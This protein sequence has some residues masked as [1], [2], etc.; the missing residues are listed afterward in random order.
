V[1]S[2]ARSF[3][4]CSTRS[5]FGGKYYRVRPLSTPLCVLS[6]CV[7]RRCSLLTDPPCC[8]HIELGDCVAFMPF[9]QPRQRRYGAHLT[10]ARCTQYP[11]AWA[12]ER[13]E[14]AN[15][16]GTSAVPLCS[17]L[18]ALVPAG[19]R[20]CDGKQEY[21]F[22]THASLS[23]LSTEPEQISAPPPCVRPRCPSARRGG[24]LSRPRGSRSHAP[25]STLHS[26]LPPSR[27]RC[28]RDSHS[29]AP[30]AASRGARR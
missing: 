7:A 10:N 3:T 30:T 8:S 17:P 24:M 9:I 14:S 25:T 22:W 6:R 26:E 11:T 19:L 16:R 23:C 21:F 4:A 28:P 20:H 29:R 2:A 5:S 15:S 12:F 18:V 27:C 13:L 1:T